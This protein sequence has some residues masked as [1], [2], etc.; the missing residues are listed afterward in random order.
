MDAISLVKYS[1][2]GSKALFQNATSDP[3]KQIL[4]PLSSIIRLALLNFKEKGSKISISNNR[5]YFQSPSL[6]QGPTRWAYGDNRNDLHNLCTPIEKAVV[7]YDPCHNNDIKQI[8]EYAVK[9]LQNL[10]MAY[11][12]DKNGDS[13][14][15]CHSIVH[16]IGIIN[17]RLQNGSIPI[18]E[19]DNM[20][21]LKYLWNKNEITVI[22]NLFS[23]ATEKLEKHEDYQYAINAIDAI[24]DGKDKIISNISN[25]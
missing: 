6:L 17:V 5:I 10:K 14:L 4:D 13:N 19:N 3:N 20:D 9:G 1:I 11:I 24:L 8:F 16:Y 18:T 15:V 2:N 25:N 23:I 7:W 21:K 22:N 12:R